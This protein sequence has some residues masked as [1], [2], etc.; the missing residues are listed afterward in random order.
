[1]RNHIKSR[2]IN[3]KEINMKLGFIGV[4]NIASAVIEGLATS[5][6]DYTTI[7]LSPRSKNT[8][9]QLANKFTNVYR[10]EDNQQVLDQSEIIFIAVRPTDTGEILS[11]LKNLVNPTYN[12][13]F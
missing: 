8:S 4:G 6:L 13:S 1:M 10:L 5:N 2:H 12:E 7:N 11:N 9:E 3:R